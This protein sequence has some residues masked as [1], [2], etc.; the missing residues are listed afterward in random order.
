MNQDLHWVLTPLENGGGRK[1]NTKRGLRSCPCRKE[2]IFDVNP[3]LSKG[4]PHYW[5][6]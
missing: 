3:M 5:V 1:C 2:L 4:M 6:Q